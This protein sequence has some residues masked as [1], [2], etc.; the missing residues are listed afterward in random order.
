M[1]AVGPKSS[2]YQAELLRTSFLLFPSTKQKIT[3]VNNVS[4]C[5]VPGQIALIWS[6][7]PY[8]IIEH[9]LLV[10]A[11]FFRGNFSL[12]PASMLHE[13]LVSSRA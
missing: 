4:D 3:D 7:Y 13:S 6:H 11:R 1:L 2:S 10:A 9:N 8:D 12:F 5:V